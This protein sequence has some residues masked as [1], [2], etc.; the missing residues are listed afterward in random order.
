MKF[1]NSGVMLDKHRHTCKN[2]S[3]FSIKH[4]IWI[5]S[6]I[7]HSLDFLFLFKF[8]F[9][10]LFVLTSVQF[11]RLVMSDSLQPHEPQHTSPLSPSPTPESTQ[12]NVHRV[13][14]G[15]QP[16]HPLSSSS[17]PAL[18]LSQDQGLFQWVSS[19]HQVA[20]LLEFQLQH[21]SHQWTPRT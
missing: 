8:T 18:N 3:V 16:S 15:I 14:D 7:H 19:S 2:S 6:S 4:N 9:L 20:K 21:Q 13:D 12:T 10:S 5:I 1:S 17:P 11:S